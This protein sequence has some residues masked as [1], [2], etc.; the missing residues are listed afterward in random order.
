MKHDMHNDY[1]DI[2]VHLRSR[3]ENALEE[4]RRHNRLV[5]AVRAAVRSGVPREIVADE[6]GVDLF[7]L[8]SMLDE[9]LISDKALIALEAS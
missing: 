6:A 9:E 2:I 7:V 5:M 3:D 4:A 8:Q 1:S